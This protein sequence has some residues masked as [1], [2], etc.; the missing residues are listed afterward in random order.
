MRLELELWPPQQAWS[1][2]HSNDG[3]HIRSSLAHLPSPFTPSNVK[4]ATQEVTQH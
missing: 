2:H 3:N 4:Q 1:N